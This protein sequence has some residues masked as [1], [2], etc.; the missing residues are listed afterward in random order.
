MS[1]F[2]F[3]SKNSNRSNQKAAKGKQI[4]SKYSVLFI[5]LSN[6]HTWKIMQKHWISLLPKIFLSQKIFP[7]K[8]NCGQLNIIDFT[9]HRPKMAAHSLKTFR[10]FFS[11]FVSNFLAWWNFQ[12]IHSI[13]KFAIC[14]LLLVSILTLFLDFFL[15][16]RFT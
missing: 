7:S 6:F 12:D 5:I 9:N 16:I 2:F 8:L 13:G 10:L 4:K 15:E 1:E 3:Q 14:K 11:D